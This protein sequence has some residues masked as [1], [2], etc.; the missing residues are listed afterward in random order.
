[1][2][3]SVPEIKDIS[4]KRILMYNE[5]CEGHGGV[6]GKPCRQM[7][8][9]SEPGNSLQSRVSN[10]QRVGTVCRP[11]GRIQPKAVEGRKWIK[12][13]GRQKKQ[14]SAGGIQFGK[15]YHHADNK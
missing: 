2:V 4:S 5:N 10:G 7:D 9:T 12:D 6:E 15:I 3:E 8:Q 13:I 1:M 14:Q 11:V